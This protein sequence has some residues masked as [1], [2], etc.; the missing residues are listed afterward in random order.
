MHGSAPRYTFAV[1]APR[2]PR[3][4]AASLAWRTRIEELPPGL[5]ERL[6]RGQPEARA[7]LFRRYAP[8]VREILYLQGMCDDIDEG[9]QEVFVKVFR[10]SL[11]REETFLGWFYR[12]ILNTGRDLGRRRRTR[13]GVL[14]RLQAVAPADVAAVDPEPGG[15]PALRAAL[16][17]LGPE[18]RETV[19]LR[20]F[21]DFSL[22]EI[23]ACQEV[24]IGTVKSRLHTAM[25]RLRESLTAAGA[26]D[27][28]RVR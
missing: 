28:V 21:A 11:P 25:A 16:A 27:D 5:L 10:A 24:P 7:E 15:D 18:F 4:E 14:R 3:A 8:R 17:E 23:A 19:A 20:F 12:V 1:R 9:V 13:Q 22:E 26:A 2:T 6:R